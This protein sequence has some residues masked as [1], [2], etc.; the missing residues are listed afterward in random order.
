MM[1]S[2]LALPVDESTGRGEHIAPGMIE[3]GGGQ[4]A[5]ERLAETCHVHVRAPVG[6]VGAF[7]RGQPLSQRADGTF[8]ERRPP[9]LV[10]LP[11]ADNDLASVEIDVLHP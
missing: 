8:R 9:V 7:A 3:G 2:A 11:S 5:L 6:A 4:L 1:T 10:A